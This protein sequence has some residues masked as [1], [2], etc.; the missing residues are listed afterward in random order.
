MLDAWAWNQRPMMLQL[1]STASSTPG[2]SAVPEEMWGDIVEKLKQ[3][4]AAPGALEPD[5][6][7]PTELQ[8]LLGPHE[9]RAAVCHDED[10]GVLGLQMLANGHTVA[11]HPTDAVVHAV[12]DT[13]TH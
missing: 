10:A 9:H 6:P 11:A 5:E 8:C 4:Y 3:A 13:D 1:D 12:G 2:R 7:D